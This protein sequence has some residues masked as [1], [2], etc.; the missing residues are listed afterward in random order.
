[1]TRVLVLAEYSPPPAPEPDPWPGIFQE[2]VTE[3]GQKFPL[4][5]EGA[6]ARLRPGTKGYSFPPLTRYTGEAPELAGS[7]YMGTREEERPVFWPIMLWGGLTSQEWMDLEAKFFDLLHPYG[8]V[9]WTVTQP[10]GQTRRLKVRLVDDGDPAY[11]T[12]PGL[13][14]WNTYGLR[15]MAEY[16]FWRGNPVTATW[17]NPLADAEFIDPDPE[18]ALYVSE[19]LQQSAITLVNPGDIME[20]PQWWL[21]GPTTDPSVLTA[22]GKEITVP[23]NIA[24]GK[25]LVLDADPRNRRAVQ[26]NTPDLAETFDHQNA[27]VQ[28]RLATGTDRT[29][30][31]AESTRWGGLV[32][33]TNTVAIDVPGTSAQVRVTLIPSY[34]RAYGVGSN[35]PA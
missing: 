2:I 5:G 17:A 13:L 1:M 26:I 22:N 6:F 12:L 27:T 29:K 24:D 18:I 32:R 30:E 3:S 34:F 15:L 35:A 19:L 11:E 23:F 31:L 10:S 21:H 25:T 28:A 33:G 7:W 8:T 14:N 16:P 9:Y 4:Q 20:Y